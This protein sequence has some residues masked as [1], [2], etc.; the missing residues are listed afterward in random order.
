MLADLGGANSLS[1]GEIQI[2]KRCAQISARC[3][4]M[5]RTAASGGSFD[6]PTYAMATGHL[7][8]ALRAIG[9]KRMPRDITPSLRT[10]IEAVRAPDPVDDP[11][12]RSMSGQ[13]DEA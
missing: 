3:E 1:T 10:Y 13:D 11:I 8:R 9:L 5:E 4:L 6:L 12:V 2:A 7:V